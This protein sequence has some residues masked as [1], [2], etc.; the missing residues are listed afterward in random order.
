MKDFETKPRN[1]H[2]FSDEDY[3]RA[4]QEVELY[5]LER[6][7][8]QI[9]RSKCQVYEEGEKSTKY[10]LGLEKRRA[11]NGTIDSLKIDDDTEVNN[12]KDVLNEIKT[13]YK[14][15]FSK[16]VL[17]RSDTKQFLESLNLP[18]ISELD[19]LMC[20]QELTLGDLKEAMLSM[21]DDKSPRNELD[22]VIL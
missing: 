15:L 8:G 9:L 22:R 3:R 13:F 17:P 11:I 6:T 20:D 10:F 7:K 12:Y 19:K 16:K 14:D 2:T 21:C 1:E 18:K 4:K 5:H